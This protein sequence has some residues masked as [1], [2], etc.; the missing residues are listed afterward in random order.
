MEEVSIDEVQSLRNEVQ[1]LRHQLDMRPELGEIVSER[2]RRLIEVNLSLRECLAQCQRALTGEVDPD[3]LTKLLYSL[4]GLLEN[5]FSAEKEPAANM[6]NVMV[7]D[8][9]GL[10]GASLNQLFLSLREALSIQASETEQ[11]MD[12]NVLLSQK[13]TALMTE[14]HHLK[15]LLKRV[16]C[17]HIQ[18]VC[19]FSTRVNGE[20]RAGHEPQRCRP[21]NF[22]EKWPSEPPVG[23]KNSR[24]FGWSAYCNPFEDT[25]L[26]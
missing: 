26:F 4:Q 13:Y 8:V 16:G 17:F 7:E 6:P 18:Q 19:H 3:T 22:I 14:N 21:Q 10:D 9:S 20:G 1:H 24:S 11:F 25:M 12:K 23:P 5:S 15:E 2:I